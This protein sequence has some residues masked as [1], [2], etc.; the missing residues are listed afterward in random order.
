M[1]TRIQQIVAELPRLK[2]P[3][4][5]YQE[6]E[7]RFAEGDV[8]F[9][10]DLAIA[11]KAANV[12]ANPPETW[13][14]DASFKFL[15]RLL[16]TTPGPHHVE[17]VLRLLAVPPQSD[18]K[19]IQF[20]ASVLAASQTLED[21]SPAFTGDGSGA[22]DNMRACL[23]HELALREVAV[24]TV[25]SIHQWAGSPHWRPHPLGDLPNQLAAFEKDPALPEYSLRGSVVS[26]PFLSGR[27]PETVGGTS[28][29]SSATD[30]TTE[31]FRVNALAVVKNWVENSNARV[32]A[33]AFN[34]TEPVESDALPA[35][36][37]TLGMES[38]RGAGG[39][40]AFRLAR[41]TG[42]WAWRLLFAAAA[43][44]GAYDGGHF[45]AHGRLHAW[46]S[47]AALVG[48][49]TETSPAQLEQ[50]VGAWS[51]FSFGGATPW[52]ENIAWDLGLVAVS[53]D[54]RHV[55]VLAATDTD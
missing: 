45:G 19:R 40:S 1:S 55:T 43:T 13:Q 3:R 36:L 14:Y 15:L 5:I 38:L 23:V 4:E 37:T 9:V 46:R 24:E 49:T 7:Q 21:L 18:Q 34:L 16:A 11:V 48:A 17:Q 10:A 52:F 22:T 32:E 28:C 42:D 39:E 2:K 8:E 30:A 6:I 54:S 44:G 41:I 20:F 35:L 27:K 51:W 50:Q 53:P 47:I 33:R 31:T 25:P 26:T 12:E 29:S